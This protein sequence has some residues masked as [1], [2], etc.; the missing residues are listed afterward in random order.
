MMK[1]I[2]VLSVLSSFMFQPVQ[3]VQ[4]STEEFL[5]AANPGEGDEEEKLT[6]A[7]IRARYLA[8]AKRMNAEQIEN[9]RYLDCSGGGFKLSDVEA[10]PSKRKVLTAGADFDLDFK[11]DSKR[12]ICKDYKTLIS[13]KDLDLRLLNTK[14]LIDEVMEGWKKEVDCKLE[15]FGK[16]LA[17][18]MKDRQI[19]ASK[20]INPANKKKIGLFDGDSLIDIEIHGHFGTTLKEPEKKA[21]GKIIIHTDGSEIPVKLSRRGGGG[22]IGCPIPLLKVEW[23]KDAPEVQNT[24]FDPIKD[25]DMKWVSHCRNESGTKSIL[26]EYLTQKWAEASGIPHMKSRLAK[27]V[28]FDMDSQTQIGTNYGIFLEP[29]K[30]LAKRYD[31]TII[32][33]QNPGF[34]QYFDYLKNPNADP[35]RGLPMMIVESLTLNR[36]YWVGLRKNTVILIDKM[37][38]EDE[39]KFKEQGI[40]FA[41]VPYDMGSG[42]AKAFKRPKDDLSF[43]R[44]ELSNVKAGNTVHWQDGWE[45][46]GLARGKKEEWRKEFAVQGQKILLRKKE[47]LEQIKLIPEE[48]PNDMTAHVEDFFKALEK[49]MQP[50]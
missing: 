29:A 14:A 11:G 45:D 33:D 44:E 6:P 7:Q 16:K 19:E 10:D 43:F 21:E 38:K 27:V 40:Y 23:D 46:Q 26:Y 3:A 50:E 31:K 35:K 25:N 15:Q 49:E 28:Y 13:S 8:V 18:Q 2:V 12:P 5:M 34:V 17:Q 42:Y 1:I 24:L 36:D 4:W 32:S 48:M 30:D 9:F 37:K 47:I 41:A 20:V 39:P 22:R